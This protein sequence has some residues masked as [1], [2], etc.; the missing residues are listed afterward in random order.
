MEKYGGEVEPV[1]GVIPFQPVFPRHV[2]YCRDSFLSFGVVVADVKSVEEEA[3]IGCRAFPF[4][5]GI[6]IF[7]LYAWFYYRC[8]CI[9]SRCQGIFGS[10]CV[11]GIGTMLFLQAIANMAVA[12]G[13][14]PVTGQTLPFISY[15][16]SSYICLGCGIGIIQSVAHDQNKK[17]K[18][19]AE[20][21]QGQAAHADDSQAETA[22]AD[23]QSAMES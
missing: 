13:V 23:S 14:L 15:G 2:L 3:K 9:A 8:I 6:A 5:A 20:T 19:L 11:A 12:V 17:R 22:P 21:N 10:L 7:I 18:A 4:F 16:G 1:G